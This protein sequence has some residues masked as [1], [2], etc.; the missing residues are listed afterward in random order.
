M[1]CRFLSGGS[2]HRCCFKGSLPLTRTLCIELS[3]QLRWSMLHTSGNSSDISTTSLLSESDKWQS[4]ISGLDITSEFSTLGIIPD[5][6][7]TLQQPH[8]SYYLH[9]SHPRETRLDFGKGFGI[10]TVN[11]YTAEKFLTHSGWGIRDKGCWFDTVFRFSYY[12]TGMTRFTILSHILPEPRP[13]EVSK[14]PG[15]NLPHTQMTC[16]RNVM[17]QPE[18]LFPISRWNYDLMDCRPIFICGS[19]RR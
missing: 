2:P 15:C 7:P 11:Q 6:K 18:K 13:I 8:I 12:L 1:R 19:T 9:I 16:H 3:A 5:I 4:N 17:C 10:N 14:N